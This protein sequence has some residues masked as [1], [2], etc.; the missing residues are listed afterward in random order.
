MALL[1]TRLKVVLYE[2]NTGLLFEDNVRPWPSITSSTA[3][4]IFM[5]SNVG[6][7]HKVSEKGRI[8][9]K[10]AQWR[11]HK[12][13]NELLPVERRTPFRQTSLQR[14]KN[15]RITIQFVSEV[16]LLPKLF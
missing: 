6:V 2:V 15:I 13:V 7:L 1:K 10:S 16:V 9:L 3:C 11:S 8:S 14:R 5:N 4:Q 12:G